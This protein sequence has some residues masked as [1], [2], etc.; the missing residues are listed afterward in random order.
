M[1]QEDGLGLL[2]AGH[3][4]VTALSLA[5]GLFSSSIAADGKG[6]RHMGIGAD[7]VQDDVEE[8]LAA[9]HPVANAL[10]TAD[11]PLHTRHRALV[12][13]AF[14]ARRIRLMEAGVRAVAEE[15]A[16][17]WRADGSVELLSQF[18]IPL[19][20]TVISDMLGVDRTDMATFKHWGDEM[21]A[22]NLDILGHGRRREVAK[23][24]VSFHEYFVPRIE[25]RR[26]TPQD[27]LLSDLVNAEIDG[28][29]LLV[30]ELR[31]DRSLIPNMLEEVLRFD[32]PIHCTFRRVTQD[33]ELR[34]CPAKAGTMVVPMWAAAGWDPTVFEQPEVFDIHR[35]NA[36]KHL[37][38]GYGLHF[39]AGSELARLEGRIAFE[40][41]LDRMDDIRLAPD[42]DLSHRPSFAARGYNR[43]DLEFTPRA[44]GLSRSP[45]ER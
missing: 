22:G 17:A 25:E 39:C 12:N 38:F 26:R 19:P 3:A 35:A 33:T 4:D 30:A 10:F 15:L 24:V 37:S 29:Q 31:A 23:A 9:A 43:L 40:V 7:P 44:S 1:Q 21:I 45:T 18:A 2:V 5:H 11:P 32:S 20:L 13:K 34:G 28:E 41:L 14:S 36:R 6:P 27:D 16:D 8:I 42:A